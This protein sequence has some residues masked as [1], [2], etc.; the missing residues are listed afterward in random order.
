VVSQYQSVDQLLYMLK[1]TTTDASRE[2]A[3]T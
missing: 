3:R 2:F 1:K